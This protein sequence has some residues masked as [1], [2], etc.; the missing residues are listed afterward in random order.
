MKLLTCEVIDADP[1]SRQLILDFVMKTSGLQMKDD[2]SSHAD[3][4][5]IDAELNEEQLHKCHSQLVVISANEKF[6][7]SL[8]QE[9]IAD[10]LY[11]PELTYTRFKQAIERVRERNS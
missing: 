8:F 4:L 11:K 1:L 10:F 7:H 9:E 2:E 5:F 3:I 6:I